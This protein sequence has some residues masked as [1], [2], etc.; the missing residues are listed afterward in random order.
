MRFYKLIFPSLLAVGLGATAQAQSSSDAVKAAGLLSADKVKQGSTVQA[1]VVVDISKGYHIN[2][3]KPLDK[4]LIPVS[5]KIEPLDGASLSAVIYPRARMRRFPFSMTP[6]SV[7]ESRA[8]LRFTIRARQRAGVNR[9]S[10][11]ES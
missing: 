7:F 1:A 8:V 10:R 6:M 9:P 4:F 11:P 3:N 5:L 2:S